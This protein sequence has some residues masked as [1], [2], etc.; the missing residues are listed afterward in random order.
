MLAAHPLIT[1]SAEP[2]VLLPFLYTL[3]RDGV[4]AEYGHS[5]A[6]QAID[7]FCRFHLDGGRA[8][9]LEEGREFFLRLYT[10]AAAG[11]PYFLDKTPRYH[12]VAREL[13]EL[14]PDAKVIFLWRNPLAVA[15]SIID[16]WN[17]GHWNLD[18]H[19][20]DL[21]RGLDRLTAA[22]PAA[23]GRAVSLRYE[24][25]VE[26]PEEEMGR[27]LR[28][29]DVPEHEAVTQ[30]FTNVRFPGSMGDS[31]G[32][33]IY[34]GVSREPLAKWQRTLANPIRRTWARR[35]LDWIGS[36]RLAVQGYDYD[37]LR[38]ELAALPLRFDESAG[39]VGRIA[40]RAFKRRLR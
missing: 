7:E 14:F 40:Y 2:W 13:L 16:S 8:R 15:A 6:V 18:T 39:D 12:L 1:S 27:V 28:S 23:G 10:Q 31:Q 37:S 35:Y 20:V 19:K 34:S 5:T 3:R 36:E 32:A 9:Y 17:A 38:V 24:D 21:Y 22:W 33:M 25:L 4:Q 29:L 26:R 11:R 30:D